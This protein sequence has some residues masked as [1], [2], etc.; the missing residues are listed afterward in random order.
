[1][2][3]TSHI[4]PLLLALFISVLIVWSGINPS[5]RAVWYAEILPVSIVFVALVAT[6]RLFRFSNLAY[7]FMSFWLIMHTIGAE[8]GRASCRERV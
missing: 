6:Y 3:K 4:I 8:I 2:Q 5:D 1:M 7:V